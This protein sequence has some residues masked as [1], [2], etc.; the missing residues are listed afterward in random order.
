MLAGR[1][2]V[3]LASRGDFIDALP[4]PPRSHHGAPELLSPRMH[5]S[6]TPPGFAPS[7]ICLL[8]RLAS[9]KTPNSR[10]LQPE[11]SGGSALASCD[12]G[13]NLSRRDIWGSG[14]DPVSSGDQSRKA[15][16]NL[17]SCTATA[18]LRL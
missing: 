1:R 12:R 3:D 14:L 11:R 13:T 5:A 8:S 7:P 2:F 6:Q 16:K 10:R 4:R 15:D 17:K 18:R 9:L